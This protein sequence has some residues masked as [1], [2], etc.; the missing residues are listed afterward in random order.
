MKEFD[1]VYFAAGRNSFL[2]GGIWVYGLD[3]DT[4]RV[5]HR[6]HMYGPYGEN[7]FPIAAE[8]GRDQHLATAAGG[9]TCCARPSALQVFA[10]A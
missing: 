10:I 3:P 5:I 8:A 4:G 2:D 7:G 6:R 9:P 1:V